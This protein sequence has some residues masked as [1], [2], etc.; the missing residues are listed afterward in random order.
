MTAAAPHLVLA[1]GGLANGLIALRMREAHPDVPITV[2]EAGPVAGGNHTWSFHGGDLSE[3]QHRFIEPLV[4]HRWSAQEVRFP[5]YARRMSSSYL[6]IPSSALAERI[7]ATPGI[8][9]RTGVR[10]ARVARRHVETDTGDRVEGSAVIDGRGPDR[11]DGLLLGFQKFLG[12]EVRTRQPHGVERPVIMDA[13]VS[14]ADGYR[15]VYVLPFSADTLLIE[16]TRYSDGHALSHGELTEAIEAYAEDHGWEIAETLREENGV[17][18]IL[19]AGDFER[20][21]PDDA[22]APARAGLRAGLFHPTTGYSL[23]QA[24]SLADAI[25]ARWP[26]DGDELASFTRDFVRRYWE[27][28]GL[29]RLL[30]RMLFKAGRPEQ[31]YL[32]MQRFYRLSESLITN[33]YASRLTLPQKARILTGKPPVPFF[34]ALTLVPER[35]FL[36]KE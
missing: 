30:N 25:V 8:E 2:I 9:L 6:S 28:T 21:W 5:A 20:F 26:M 24:L 14:Q 3:H 32:V 33:F 16:D 22:D 12:L 10:A 7:A 19:M 13:T 29:F 35:P 31:R 27:D 1:G 18:P 23:P 36:P 17:L 11:S 34:K 15:F 4:R